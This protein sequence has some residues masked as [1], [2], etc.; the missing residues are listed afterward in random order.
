MSWCPK[1]RTEY[2]E[3]FTHCADCGAELVDELPELVVEMPAAADLEPVLLTTIT[4][5]QEFQRFSQLLHLNRIPFYSLDKDTGDYMRIYMG[6]SVYGQ[7]VYVRRRDFAVASQL[8][9][10]LEGE[11]TDEEMERAYDAF[12]S[13]PQ[14][15]PSELDDDPDAEPVSSGYGLLKVFGIFFGA[16][17]LLWLLNSIFAWW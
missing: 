7:D 11:Y 8:L 6:F 5:E 16:L 10:N 4:G 9:A 14:E 2:R 15:Q 17:I 13:T 3:G 1:C 12:L